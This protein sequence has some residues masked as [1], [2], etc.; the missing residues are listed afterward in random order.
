MLV[1]S[2][3]TERGRVLTSFQSPL[4][5]RMCWLCTEVCVHSR[6]ELIAVDVKQA[7]A[8]TIGNNM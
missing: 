3:M 7:K 1:G 2:A 5:F 4:M 8:E 6:F